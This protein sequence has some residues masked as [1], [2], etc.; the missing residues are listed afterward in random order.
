MKTNGPH[1]ILSVTNEGSSYIYF[2]L[3][4]YFPSFRFVFKTRALSFCV[5]LRLHSMGALRPFNFPNFEIPEPLLV[6]QNRGTTSLSLSMHAHS[7][8]CL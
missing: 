1:G 4:S 2:L 7:H 8:M 6:S 3:I 5:W